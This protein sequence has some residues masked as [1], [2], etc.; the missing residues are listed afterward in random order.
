MQQSSEVKNMNSMKNLFLLITII[1]I[2]VNQSHVAFASSFN[3]NDSRENYMQFNSQLQTK[4]IALDVFIE[5]D[6]HI[7]QKLV[8]AQNDEITQDVFPSEYKVK[9]GDSLY[10]IAKSHGLHVK[11]IKEWNGLK[12]DAVFTQ[13][14]LVLGKTSKTIASIASATKIHEVAKHET[15]ASIAG[16]YAVDVEQ[17][18]AW[19]KLT[20]TTQNRNK[21]VK[22]D[23]NE[24]SKN[25]YTEET[26]KTMQV[27]V[28]NLNVRNRP[29]ASGDALGKLNKNTK[30][31]VLEEINGWTKIKHGEKSAWVSSEY[32]RKVTSI[33]G[34]GKTLI[35]NT[36][37]LNLRK[38]PDVNSE[39]I[40]VLYMGDKVEIIESTEG[41]RYVKTGSD[42]GWASAE[43]LI[44]KNRPTPSKEKIIVIDAGHG[45]RD[46]GT[47]VENGA[48]EKD[49]T[50]AFALKI[51]S[52]LIQNGYTVKMVRT[53]D[54]TCSKSTVSA[55]ELECRIGIAKKNEAHA[56]ISIHANAGLAKA[57]GTETFYN[58][59]N[60][61]AEENKLLAETIHKHYQP[62]FD[63]RDR[64]VKNA[65][66]YV[67]LN[68]SVPSVLIE[69]GFLTN[70]F[71]IANLTSPAIQNRV[72][73][74][75]TKGLDEYFGF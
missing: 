74:G 72:A 64:G 1:A 65:E 59:S 38:K 57:K 73:Q 55:E 27:A 16:K 25:M 19:N 26:L 28:D 63:S 36:D 45:G 20:D 39:I 18:R 7:G 50:L 60:S 56:Y 44:P 70:D 3:A 46:P 5:K 12:T 11:Q 34:D 41:W 6:L 31:E 61:N 24:E 8:I 47:L 14:I 40:G 69:I 67:I 30:V 62:A 21:Q 43:F 51:Q 58:A 10:E 35:V 68:N 48:K 32:L 53:E 75:I 23:Q 52:D 29:D 37:K 71:D 4:S 49:I 33:N 66:Y 22:K 9:L 2:M 42:L 17:L 54:T 13:Q 15:L